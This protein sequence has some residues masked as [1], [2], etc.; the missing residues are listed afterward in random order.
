MRAQ[1][2]LL[3]LEPH[4]S[5]GLSLADSGQVEGL[6][7]IA[8]SQLPHLAIWPG[9][10]RAGWEGLG[11]D[12]REGWMSCHLWLPALMPAPRA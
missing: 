11:I 10:T 3:Y 4:F 5:Q 7:L 2:G 1:A 6:L 12:P 9:S 8:L